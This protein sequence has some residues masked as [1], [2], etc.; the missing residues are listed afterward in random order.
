MSKLRATLKI[1]TILLT[2]IL[3]FLIV[4][5]VIFWLTGSEEL[6]GIICA[7]I[8]VAIYSYIIAS[9]GDE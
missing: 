4:V 6:T 9:L 5:S 7:I 8:I 1:F 2:S 3:T